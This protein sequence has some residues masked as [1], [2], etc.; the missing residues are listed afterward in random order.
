MKNFILYWLSG[1][2]ETVTGTDIRDAFSRAG[3]GAGAVRAM[4]F[5]AG[6]GEAPDYTWVPAERKWVPVSAD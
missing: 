2:K 5:Y 6:E 4:D 1:K 3:Y